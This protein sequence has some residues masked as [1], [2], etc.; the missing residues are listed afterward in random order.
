MTRSTFK[1]YMAPVKRRVEALWTFVST[2]GVEP[3]TN[4]AERALRPAVIWRRV[5]FGTQS[6]RGSRFVERILTVCAT[7]KQQNRNVLDYLTA[8]SC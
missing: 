3:T 4:P 8:A 2:E 1:R 7:L 5:S 6:E